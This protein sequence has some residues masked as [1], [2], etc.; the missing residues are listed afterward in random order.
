MDERQIIS[1]KEDMVDGVC[2]IK[3]SVGWYYNIVLKLT[4]H[5]V[6]V[7]QIQHLRTRNAEFPF[8]VFNVNKQNVRILGEGLVAFA[9]ANNL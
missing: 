4:K 2:E 1:D 6:E 8:K 7:V 5:D 3:L 9:D